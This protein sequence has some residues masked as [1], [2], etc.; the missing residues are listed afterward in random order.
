MPGV[1]ALRSIG[2]PQGR[3]TAEH[4]ENAEGERRVVRCRLKSTRLSWG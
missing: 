1:S 4:A 3:F 2:L